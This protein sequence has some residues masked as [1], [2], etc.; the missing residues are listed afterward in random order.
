EIQKKVQ[1]QISLL[2][3]ANKKTDAILNDILNYLTLYDDFLTT[4]I[5]LLDSCKKNI[6]LKKWN[7]KN[8]NV[9][10]F[11]SK[12]KNH[13]KFIKGVGLPGTI[14]KTKKHQLWRTK[15]I[16]KK[17]IRVSSAKEIGVKSI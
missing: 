2:F 6:Y 13:T 5:W 4:E 14:W 8:K 1:N 9:E 15:E 10:K 16:N 12:T 7:A 11:Y 3:K 17:F